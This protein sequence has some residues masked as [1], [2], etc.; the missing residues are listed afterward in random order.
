MQARRL[1]KQALDVS[2]S[3]PGRDEKRCSRRGHQEEEA[4]VKIGS[5]ARGHLARKRAEEGV[6]QEPCG[7]ETKE[8]GGEKV[9]SGTMEATDAQ[10]QQE[11]NEGCWKASATPTMASAVEAGAKAAALAASDGL[12]QVEALGVVGVRAFFDSLGLGSCTNRLR[13]S[14][15]GID[16]DKLAR[17]ARAPDPDAELLAAGVKA[18]LHRVKILSALG[19]GVG[20]TGGAVPSLPST[21][22]EDVPGGG[23][24][25]GLAHVTAIAAL[26]MVRQLRKEQGVVADVLLCRSSGGATQNPSR[27]G[28]GQE[29][30]P[31]AE[32]DDL[33]SHKAAWDSS[34]GAIGAPKVTVGTGT[35]A[36]T[37]EEVSFM[38]LVLPELEEV[39][40]TQVRL[41]SQV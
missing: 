14:S 30:P 29:L 34:G 26:H 21:L 38:S 8:V 11:E 24:G 20:I 28:L 37:S 16:G 7:P 3:T 17:I 6:A 2:D 35:A 25:G 15:G 10:H 41:S 5:A 31:R 4:A 32:G 40:S 39:L 33:R 22:D 9:A 18:R 13:E 23:G 12:G 1:S 27:V 36:R 19:V